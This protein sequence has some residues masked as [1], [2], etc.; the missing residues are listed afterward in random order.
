MNDS[1]LNLDLFTNVQADFEIRQYKILAALKQIS[2]DFQ[3]NRI[4]PHLSNLVELREVLVEIKKRLKDLR[5]DFPKRI[6]NIDLVNKV[7]E[8]EVVF[9]EGADLSEVEK[10]IEWAQPHLEE[11]IEEGRTIFDF[12]NNEVKLEEVGVM[13]N[14]LDEGYFFVPDNEESKLLLFQYEMSIFQSSKDE[15]RSLKTQFLK[16]LEKGMVERSPNSIKLE[17]IKEHKTLPNPA[18]YSFNTDLQFPFTETI[19]PVAKR[20]LMRRLAS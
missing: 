16:A 6:K 11:T 8:H 2:L 5:N 18:T 9:M 4:Y 10:L 1:S 14:Y 17:L 12:V 19:F 20:K 7:I 3:R 13:P 15:Y